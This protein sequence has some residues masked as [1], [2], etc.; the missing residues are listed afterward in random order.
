M[1]VAEVQ[2]R[3]ARAAAAEARAAAHQEAAAIHCAEL[4]PGTAL[5]L[6]P[7]P[8]LQQA[9]P[10]PSPPR[11]LSP[12]WQTSGEALA[13]HSVGVREA[14]P[15]A[16]Q[17][18]CPGEGAARG[19]SKWDS[20]SGAAQGPKTA[21]AAA[22][23]AAAETGHGS[24]EAAAGFFSAPVASATAQNSSAAAAL[25]AAGVDCGWRAATPDAQS[26]AHEVAASLSGM[27]AEAESHPAA[28]PGTE[29]DT[30]W[31]GR[32]ALAAV[33]RYKALLQVRRL[34]SC[35]A[36]NIASGSHC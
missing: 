12:Q 35:E 9:V 6:G 21:A 20:L 30:Q 16:A 5:G 15:C 18:D 19:P 32:D 36:G 4:H 11:E 34:W 28:E 13:Q 8:A 1:A 29:L 17:F 10:A 26:T 23:S 14:G 7:L 25:M 31:E 33:V 24:P 27:C 3:D 22:G 2:E